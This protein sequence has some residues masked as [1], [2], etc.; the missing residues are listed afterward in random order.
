[1]VEEFKQELTETNKQVAQLQARQL[2]LIN[3][4]DRAGVATTDGARTMIEW[5]AT[6]LD[7]TTGTAR[8]LVTTANHIY[9]RDP[10][11]FED[12]QAGE[13]TLDRAIATLRLAATKA[14]NTVID[15]SFDLDLTAVNRLT[16]HQRRICRKDE[17]QT[18]QDRHLV[19][20]PSL[21]QSRWRG[22]F[23]LPGINGS[24]VDTALTQRADEMRMLPGGDHFTRPQR[25]ADALVM[26]S[27]DSLDTEHT[28]TGS[29]GGANVTVFVDMDQANGTGGEKGAEIQYGPR[30]GPAVLEELICNSSVQLVGLQDGKPIVT[31]DNTKTIPPAV[32][33]FVAWR[34]GG[35]AI[36]GCTSRYRLQPHHIQH[37]HQHG[38]HHPDNLVT[39]CWFH[40]HIAI[41]GTGFTLKPNR[42]PGCQKLTKPNHGHDPP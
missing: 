40:H 25:L 5:T 29:D 41:H 24:I 8:D 36:S 32:R 17:Q 39:L 37:R 9:R 27:K 18:F 30:V 42:P 33:R 21:D 3:K 31:S 4:L 7:T 23:E 35:C 1:M 20:Q 13:V 19:I 15:R 26:I 22:W 38:N 2:F 11:L 14:P 12:M 16:H 10:I 6:T 34:D 28:E